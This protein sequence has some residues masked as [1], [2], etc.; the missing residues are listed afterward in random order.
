MYFHNPLLACDHVLQS[1]EFYGYRKDT[2]YQVTIIT[3]IIFHQY[4]I[5]ARTQSIRIPNK[6]KAAVRAFPMAIHVLAFFTLILLQDM[7]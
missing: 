5:E 1:R 4:Y 2:N 6:V 7:G 3:I